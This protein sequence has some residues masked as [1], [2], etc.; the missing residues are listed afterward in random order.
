MWLFYGTGGAAFAGVHTHTTAL[1]GFDRR[2][3]LN[4][5][6]VGGGLEARLAQNWSV[7]AEYLYVDLDDQLLTVDTSVGPP[8]LTL[9]SDFTRLHVVR[10]GLN[11]RFG[12]EPVVARY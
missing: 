6:T 11:Y 2:D 9:R 7:K 3:T 8:P 4:G 5:W 12:V 1:L 10:F